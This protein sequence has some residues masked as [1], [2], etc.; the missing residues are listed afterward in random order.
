MRKIKQGDQVIV[1][2]GRDKGKTGSVS[3]ILKDGRLLVES[4]NIV[5]KHVKANPNQN[6]AGGIIDVEAPIQYSNV[7][8]YNSGTSKADRVGFKYLEDGTKVRVFKSNG[9]VIDA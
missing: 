9:E 1:I 2:A 8:I 5:K 3:R 7:A 6:I 4:I